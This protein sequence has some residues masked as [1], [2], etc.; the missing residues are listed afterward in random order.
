MAIKPKA[1]HRAHGEEEE[2]LMNIVV[3]QEDSKTGN[4]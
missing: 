2:N 4:S 1:L 3:I